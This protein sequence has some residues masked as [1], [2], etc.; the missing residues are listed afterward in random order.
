MITNVLGV[1]C[2][3][4]FVGVAVAAAAAAVVVVVVILDNTFSEHNHFPVY[5]CEN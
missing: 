1:R 2:S 5:V 4:L 3:G